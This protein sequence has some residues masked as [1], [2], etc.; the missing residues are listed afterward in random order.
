MYYWFPGYV[1]AELNPPMLTWMPYNASQWG[2]GI[3]TSEAATGMVGTYVSP[4]IREGYEDIYDL[5][6]HMDLLPEA[7]AR[8]SCRDKSSGGLRYAR[9]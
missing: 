5:A 7:D 4:V 6:S 2:N 8:P 3:M 9:C 1:F